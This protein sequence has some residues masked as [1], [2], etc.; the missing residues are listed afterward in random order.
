MHYECD[1]CVNENIK[2][3]RLVSASQA[4]NLY[5]G[6][7]EKALQQICCMRLMA[8]EAYCESRFYLATDV[9]SLVRKRADRKQT[10]YAAA[11]RHGPGAL[12]SVNS[13]KRKKSMSANSRRGY[14][15]VN[16]KQPV[17]TAAAMCLATDP[18]ADRVVKVRVVPKALAGIRDENNIKRGKGRVRQEPLGVWGKQLVR[19]VGLQ[20]S[21][22]K[23]RIFDTVTDRNTYNRQEQRK[24]AKVN[25]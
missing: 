11:W 12:S 20:G 3:N 10:T 19:V 23:T 8:A 1:D 24:R 13:K 16:V 7:T 21:K 18:V 2:A 15:V 14:T 22:I 4:R 9:Q 5:E 6:V 25:N 17:N